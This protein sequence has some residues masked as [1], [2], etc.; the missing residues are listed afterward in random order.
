MPDSLNFLPYSLQICFNNFTLLYMIAQLLRFAIC[1]TSYQRRL[2]DV[3]YKL[4]QFES[5]MGI[6]FILCL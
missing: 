3:S 5:Q 1:N 2:D 6:C 4:D